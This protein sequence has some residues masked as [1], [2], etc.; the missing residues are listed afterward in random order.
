M[1]PTLCVLVAYLSGS[2]HAHALFTSADFKTQS[3]K[4]TFPP[5]CSLTWS[6]SHDDAFGPPQHRVRS[7]GLGTGQ[8]S[9]I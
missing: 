6:R 7:W 2:P 5:V 9:N 1:L 8:R 4:L 3:F